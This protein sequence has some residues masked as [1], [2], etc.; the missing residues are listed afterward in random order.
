ME[1][2]GLRDPWRV[3]VVTGTSEFPFDRLLTACAA[4]ARE[5]A[6]GAEWVVQHGPSGADLV[7]PGAQAFDFCTGEQYRRHL[8]D[9]DVVIGHA[10]LGLVLDV[11]EIGAPALLVPRREHFGEHVDDHQ[12]QIGRAID[13]PGM[14]VRADDDLTL[15][16][17]GLEELAAPGRRAPVTLGNPRLSEAVAAALGLTDA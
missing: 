1:R 2:C 9:A 14:R 16:W 6:E 10:G 5:A 15:P 12:M 13:L 8:R 11:M 4:T 17:A 7:P 3:F